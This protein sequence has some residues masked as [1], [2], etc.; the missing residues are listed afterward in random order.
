[1]CVRIKKILTSLRCRP[2]SVR[3][4]FL[5]VQFLVWRLNSV[6]FLID[7][8]FR[9]TIVNFSYFLSYLV[10]WCKCLVLKIE[11][12]SWRCVLRLFSHSFRNKR[13]TFSYIFCLIFKSKGTELPALTTK[14]IC[15]RIVF[16]NFCSI[17][18][19][20]IYRV[21]IYCFDVTASVLTSTP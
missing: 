10:S 16:S 9:H 20:L 8:S 3:C 14:A 11:T 21:L 18:F 2:N 12:G 1:M 17:N 15:N 19:S 13:E 6:R 5:F 7:Y 4:N